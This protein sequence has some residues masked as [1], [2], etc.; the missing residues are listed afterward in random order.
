MCTVSFLFCVEVVCYL[1]FCVNSVYG[2]ACQKIVFKGGLEALAPY[3]IWIL[4]N[5]KELPLICRNSQ[6]TKQIFF[7]ETVLFFFYLHKTEL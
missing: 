4:D 6:Y 7:F 5:K 2:F 1:L 3:F